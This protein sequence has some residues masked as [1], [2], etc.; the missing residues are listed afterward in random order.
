MARTIVI[1]LGRPLLNVSSCL[2]ES[3]RAGQTRENKR[4]LILLLS[5]W[6]CTQWGL[7]CRRNHLPR[8]EL[9]PRHFTLTL[10]IKIV[11]R[12]YFFCCTFPGLT[13]GGRYPSLCPAVSGLSSSTRKKLS[14][15]RDYPVPQN[16][17]YPFSKYCQGGGI[18]ESVLSRK[19]PKTGGKQTEDA[20]N[21][22][23]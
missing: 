9:L 8:G 15:L 16:L 10:K 19:Q 3:H 20:R 21:E 5:V 23:I 7:P 12:R 22:R 11:S 14:R 17:F 2:P 4:K 6:H 13:T 18:G 1:Y